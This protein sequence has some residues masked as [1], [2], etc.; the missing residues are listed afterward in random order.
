MSA[1]VLTALMLLFLAGSIY[2]WQKSE[3]LTEEKD[4]SEQ[5]AD[6]LLSV[7]LQLEGDIRSLNRQLET[8]TDEAAYLSQRLDNTQSLVGNRDRIINKFRQTSLDQ[9]HTIRRLNQT[10]TGVTTARD[11]LDNVMEAIRDKISW[12]TDSNNLLISQNK[13]LNQQIK[14]LHTSLL[15]KAPQSA[16]TGDAFRVEAI[17]RNRKETAKAKKVHALT[18]SLSIPTELQLNGTQEVYLS[19]TDE[20]RNAMVPALQTSTV[21]LADVNEVIPV[22]AMQEVN[23]DRNPQRISFSI[24]PSE[25]VKPGLYRASVFT[26]NTYLGSVEFQFRD[27]FLFF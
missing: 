6:S 8:S 27:S 17:K 4:L 14:N 13:E 3:D 20:H 21:M 15:T 18:I 19:L 12:L 16:I 5:R 23:F 24:K 2:F 25:G 10:I 26:K 9:K 7:R 11:S 22:H 1:N